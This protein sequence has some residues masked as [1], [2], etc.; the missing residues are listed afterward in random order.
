[1]KPGDFGAEEEFIGRFVFEQY[2]RDEIYVSPY[3]RERNIHVGRFDLNGDGVA[4]LF[5]SNQHSAWC[6]SIGCGDTIFEKRGGYWHNIG[7]GPLVERVMEESVCGYRSLKGTDGIYRW[8]GRYYGIAFCYTDRVQCRQIAVEYGNPERLVPGNGL[9]AP[10][11][12]PEPG[13]EK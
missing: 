11:D 13:R 8:N 10:E 4:E 1:M 6:G 7:G 9:I 12:C 5:I 3:K 2:E